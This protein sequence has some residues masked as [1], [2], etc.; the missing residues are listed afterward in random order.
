MEYDQASR[1]LSITTSL[2][3]NAV[4][5]TELEGVD[6]LS[7]PFEFRIKFVT[8]EPAAKV[9]QLLLSPVTI[10]FG[11]LA[12]ARR[13]F[14]GYVRRVTRTA[15]KEASDNQT[16]WEA[17]VVPRF[18]FLSHRSNLRPYKDK[19]LVDIIMEVFG[20]H[21]IPT[22]T[23]RATRFADLKLDYCV[24][25]RESDFAF[26]S[27]MMEKF[28]WFYCHRHDPT[29]TAMVIGDANLHGLDPLAATL[30]AAFAIE[31]DFYARPGQWVT[32]DFNA[33]NYQTVLHERPG[34]L[35]AAAMPPAHER[36]DYPGG[37]FVRSAMP[38][39]TALEPVG[40][41]FTDLAMER[42]EA[43]HHL[44]RG[45][46]LLAEIDAG[47]RLSITDAGG[48][49]TEML[50][51]AVT[52]RA[53]DYSHWTDADWGERE[54]F[55]PHYENSFA[56]IPQAVPF[57]PELATPRPVVQGP[58]T[59]KVT[60][61]GDAETDALGRV[62]LLFHW[63]RGASGTTWVRVSQGWAGN[64]FG[65]MHIPRTGDEVIVDFLEGDPDRPIVTGRVY[66]G[67]NKVP[68]T[69]PD[70][71]MQ[72]G[73]KTSRDH[74]LRFDDT[75]G[76]EEVYLR[77]AR[78]LLTEVMDSETRKIGQGNGPGTRTTE[79]KGDDQLT[80]TQ[81]NLKIKA[82][83][84][85]VEIEA[86]NEIVLKVGSSKVTITQMAVTIEGIN[87]EVKGT[88]SA[89]VDSPMTTAGGSGQTMVTGSM[90]MIG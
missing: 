44:T 10:E 66:N 45:R 56:C 87:V 24:Q 81:G 12:E 39:D 53:R 25:Y 76:E 43:R 13:H 7:K 32:A 63:D 17:E 88:A 60:T 58:Q 77:S 90:I 8:A 29:A 54:R 79:V 26:L 50:V 85:S 22:P 31:E 49:T 52:H 21:G 16:E 14:R 18:W 71:R 78:H 73:I 11:P 36:F 28:G 47:C 89:K 27:R 65:Q 6:A 4:L 68:F 61:G 9:R 1:L 83:A 3:P 64:G 19:S 33:Q 38:G 67:R 69:L 72:S 41:A 59:A 2:G 48:S 74:Q 84:G 15:E 86:M 34:K 62:K 46:S 30:G 23:I 80:V 40:R 70:K 75:E 51:T 5:L 42:E 37:Y 55:E 82:Q 35:G 20:Q 57:R